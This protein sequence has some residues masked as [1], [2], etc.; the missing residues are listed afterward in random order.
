MIGQCLV[1][2]D[3]SCK[4]TAMNFWVEGLNSPT[5]HLG[6]SGHFGNLSDCDPRIKNGLKSPPSREQ[7]DPVIVEAG[8]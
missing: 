6:P 8:S 5:H 1:I 2:D 3:I 7:L 4:Q